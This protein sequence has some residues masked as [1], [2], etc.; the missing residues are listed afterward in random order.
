MCAAQS[1]ENHLDPAVVMGGFF[2]ASYDWIVENH[3][4]DRDEKE[5]L[6]K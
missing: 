4:L 1:H 6:E 2:L 3:E 5:F